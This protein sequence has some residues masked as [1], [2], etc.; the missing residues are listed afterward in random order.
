MS[1][2]RLLTV[3][4]LVPMAL[5]CTHATTTA[6]DFSPK[7]S[8]GFA[9]AQ[10]LYGS[11]PS[12]DEKQHDVVANG[13]EAC[14]RYLENG[15]LRY[16]WPPCP[17]PQASGGPQLLPIATSA[18]ARASGGASVS[19]SASSVTPWHDKFVVEWPCAHKAE[20]EELAVVACTVP[21]P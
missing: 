4:G 20:G 8:V 12:N 19:T 13:L 21:E 9:N 15:V 11:P 2:W 16:Q 10:A 1:R 14:G 5:G 7:P 3:L 6:V 18:S 17:A